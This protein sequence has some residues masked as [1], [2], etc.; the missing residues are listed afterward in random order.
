MGLRKPKG[1]KLLTLP[2]FTIL[3]GENAM[4]ITGKHSLV[5]LKIS[6]SDHDELFCAL[7]DI[8]EEARNLNCICV[9]DQI[10]KLDYYLGGNI[11]F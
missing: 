10:F 2:L 7:K 1:F 8:I 11:K 9:E 5:I 6:E 4:S 3:K